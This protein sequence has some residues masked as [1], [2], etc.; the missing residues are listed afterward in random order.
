[1]CVCVR[2]HNIYIYILTIMNLFS[3][4]NITIMFDIINNVM[5]MFSALPAILSDKS[6]NIM[7]EVFEQFAKFFKF[8]IIVITMDF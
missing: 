3:K 5:L 1:M 7:S 8:D 4:F 6:K 2:V